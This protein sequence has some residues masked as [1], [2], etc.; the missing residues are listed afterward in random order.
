MNIEELVLKRYKEERIGA[1]LCPYRQT[2]NLCPSAC[3]TIF[4][5]SRWN[6]TRS[7]AVWPC[8]T[9]WA[10][11]PFKCL[12]LSWRISNHLDQ[13]NRLDLH[14]SAAMLWN[15][16]Q[17]IHSPLENISPNLPGDAQASF[18]CSSLI[19]PPQL[20]SWIQ[21]GITWHRT[22]SCLNS[23]RPA[24]APVRALNSL[25]ASGWFWKSSC[26]TQVLEFLRS[27]CRAS[28]FGI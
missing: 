15:L 26:G 4:P 27:I 14:S 17:V 19:H 2:F 11:F 9:P 13:R 16:L 3:I 25:A 8:S 5:G 23:L 1:N 22:S 6:A 24:H 18:I 10:L 20:S 21:G 12:I 7:S 28:L